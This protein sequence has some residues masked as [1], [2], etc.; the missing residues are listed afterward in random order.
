MA[1]DLQYVQTGEA[2]RI[3]ASAYNAFVDAAK[4]AKIRQRP[5]P[6]TI[7]SIDR[8]STI[9]KVLNDTGVDLD[10]YSVCV[11]GDVV[12]S[13]DDNPDEF[14]Q[15]WCLK[16][17]T[18]G[19]PADK[20]V[21][22]IL[23]DPLANGAIG[24]ATVAGVTPVRITVSGGQEAYK[25]AKVTNGETGYLAMDANEG[26]ARVL[27]K[28]SGTGNVWALVKLASPEGVSGE[29]PTLDA[30]LAT[31]GE[32]PAGTYSNG[33]AGVGA[34]YTVTATGTLTVDGYV[35][36]VGQSILVKD[37]ASG[38]QNGLYTVTTAG[39]VGV[40]AVLTRHGGN[41]ESA[42]FVGAVYNVGAV[43]DVNKNTEWRCTNTALPTVGTTA[44]TIA[45][46]NF[47]TGESAHSTTAGH[48]RA[49]SEP[50]SSTAGLA[51]GEGAVE[52][53]Q[54]RSTQTQTASG[55]WAAIGG[56][57]SNTASGDYSAV[58]GGLENAAS[59]DYSAA[60]GWNNTASA[61]YTVAIGGNANSATSELAAVFGGTANTASADG[62]TVAGGSYCTASAENS[63]VVCGYS[64]TASGIYSIVIAGDY[65]TASGVSSAAMGSRAVARLGGMFAAAYGRF[66]NNGDAQRVDC[67]ARNKTTD[68]TATRLYLDGAA[69]HF[70]IPS[71]KGFA[72]TANVFGIKSDGSSAAHY[73]RKFSIKNVGG[74]TSLIGSVS[75]IGTD[76]E[77]DAGYDV[78]ITADNTNDCIAIDVTGKSGETLRWVAHIQGVELEYG[79]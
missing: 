38:L 71:G 68:G 24:R 5:A 12:F 6:Q 22:A 35:T 57:E 65:N 52:W 31:A 70:T 29:A 51:R 39:A 23:L 41:D 8:N 10:Q 15:N 30:A 11:V 78:A 1:D 20:E 28:E 79:A 18:P 19:D 54:K 36:A 3:P 61:Q 50:S 7:P 77:D 74:T 76:H 49:A 34:T 32:L 46:L 27:W 4:A 66:S 9:I 14:L 69:A 26:L 47:V 64:N 53:Q 13:H 59:G 44:I 48:V 25:W 75:T 16:V 72:G 37:Q 45:P 63:A 60:G 58:L 2:F 55:D 42:E 33:V 43:G 17:N 40:Q 67:V 56:G 21:V 73:T 62:A